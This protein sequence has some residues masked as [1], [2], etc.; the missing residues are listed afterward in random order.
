MSEVLILGG[1]VAGL[2]AG[3][4]ALLSGHSVTI[5]EKNRVPGGN[6]TG[7]DRGAY[8][9]D[10]CIH[11]LT[12]TNPA[13]DTYAMWERL[14]M[15]GGVGIIETESLY[16]YEK[17]GESLSLSRDL[18]LFERRML[19]LSPRD[20]DEIRLFCDAVRTVQYMS[21]IGGR[22]RDES[23]GAFRTALAAPSLARYVRMTTGE[24]AARFSHPLIS[25]FITALL[26]ENF[27]AIALI[28]V[29]AHF[30]AG[31]ADLVR[32]GS[33]A[34]AGRMAKRFTE[35][36]G[37]LLL[38]T[39]VIRINVVGG[40]ARSATLADG[41][42]FGADRFIVTADPARV[43]GKILDAPMPRAL[44]SRYRRESL[45]RFSCFQC[46]FACPTN[47][48]PFR[49]EVVFDLPEKSARALGQKRIAVREFSHEPSFA[50]EGETVV[51]T[52]LI[53]GEKVCRRFIALA[54]M[55]KEYA[56]VKKRAA[57]D[58]VSALA[59]HYPALDGALRLVD[60]WTPETYRRFVGTEC[61][62]F[63]SFAF[64]AST[65]P[66]TLSSRIDG[67]D[68]VYLATQWQTLPGG[69]PL[70]AQCG[71]L[72]VEAIDRAEAR[73]GIGSRRPSHRFAGAQT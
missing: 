19:S 23:F 71:K 44:A 4:Y 14:G 55:P 34:A 59:E 13:T 58:V 17:D 49:G 20:A 41:R 67:V 5:C 11:W 50:P 26:T 69:L 35:L 63:M 54:A 52:M 37:E 18:D 16:T 57:S 66:R 24:L 29:C 68:N 36:G 47:S 25:G 48:L 56:T 6:L 45:E 51:Q 9:I 46:A 38:D 15:L 30:C 64:G 39:E 33:R 21:G 12:G 31:N 70:A 8:H 62:S 40:E 32:D 7:W 2:S 1:G 43:F 60:C 65:L 3:I 10:N 28:T 42:I 72:A 61:G 73:A 22:R 27:G 53:C